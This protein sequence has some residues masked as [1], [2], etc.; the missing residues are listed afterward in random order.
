MGIFKTFSCEAFRLCKIKKKL[1]V[2]NM[3]QVILKG[4]TP[5]YKMVGRSTPLT[6]YNPTAGHAFLN[7]NKTGTIWVCP[8]VPYS[9]GL[10]LG[11]R[12]LI[13]LSLIRCCRPSG[14]MAIV[15]LFLY[16]TSIFSLPSSRFR[17]VQFRFPSHLANRWWGR[18]F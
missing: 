16:S 17:F 10:I 5:H 15:M 13:L 6:T 8:S 18:G 3:Y 2:L 11:L 1:N 12:D 14:G 7:R 9:K 4:T